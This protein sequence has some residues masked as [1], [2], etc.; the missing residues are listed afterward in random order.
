MKLAE[1]GV[2]KRLAE[3]QLEINALARAFPHLVQNHNGSVPA[4]APITLKPKRSKKSNPELSKI[5]KAYWANMAPAERAARQK[6]MIAARRKTLRL[7]AKA[8]TT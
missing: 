7:R 4:V 1:Q 2:I 6:K 8:A 5:R 3:I